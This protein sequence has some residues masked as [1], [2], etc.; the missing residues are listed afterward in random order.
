MR[1]NRSRSASEVGPERSPVT[2]ASLIHAST[3]D[4]THY[5][6]W[7]SVRSRKLMLAPKWAAATC[8]H[9]GIQVFSGIEG[10]PF[11]HG[12]SGPRP[13]KTRRLVD[14]DKNSSVRA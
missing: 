3:H 11:A 1:S 6:G 9:F 8:R 2:I 4:P 5:A 12:R 7:G 13:R 14:D 10:G